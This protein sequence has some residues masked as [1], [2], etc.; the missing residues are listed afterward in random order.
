LRHI[1]AQI[2]DDKAGQTLVSASTLSRELREGIQ[3]AGISAAEKV[4]GL[5]AKRALEKGIETVVFDRGGYRYH[6]V[7]A[8]LAAA[9]RKGGLRF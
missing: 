1:Y 2:I 6:G 7:V 4:G 5:L 3:G 8:A 9:S